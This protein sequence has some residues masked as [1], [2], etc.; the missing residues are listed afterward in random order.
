M[1]DVTT[2]YDDL[3]AIRRAA[4]VLP[5]TASDATRSDLRVVI[6]RIEGKLSIALMRLS[7]EAR[8][9]IMYELDQEY[10]GGVWAELEA[11]L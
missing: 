9:D 5:E 4:Q 8:H 6:K 3:V 11:L 10:C 7:E 1:E 2:L